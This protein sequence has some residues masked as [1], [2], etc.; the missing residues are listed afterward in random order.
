LEDG[1]DKRTH[2]DENGDVCATD[3][4][5][6]IVTDESGNKVPAM[7][8]NEDSKKQEEHKNL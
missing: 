8:S 1:R 6:E 4:N 5:G 7:K 2:T 3:E